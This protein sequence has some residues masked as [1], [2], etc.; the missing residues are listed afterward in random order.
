MILIFDLDD[1]LYDEMSF[2][3]SGLCAVAKFG[4]LSFGWES[5]SSLAFM[6]THLHKHGRGKIFNEWL[7][8]HG[9]HSSSN[10]KAC[11]KT[12]RHHQPNISLFPFTS[13]LL[14]YYRNLV[15]SYLVTDGHKIVQQ[16][17]IDALCLAPLFKRALITHRFGIHHAKPSLHCFDVIRH[18]ERCA[19][20][21]LV[22][23]G[24]NPLKDF[25]NLNAVGAMTVRVSTGSHS[26]ILA[27]PGYDAS[28]T[29]PDLASLPQVLDNW[30]KKK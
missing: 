4:E 22:Y 27:L 21:E 7:R 11:V 1:T 14:G 5:A 28:V 12:Y 10:V 18:T 6:Q 29:I 2:V 26:S 3:E 30:M 24:D 17:K 8:T 15:P 20:S 23:V 16:K 9:K 19:W 13:S 25:V